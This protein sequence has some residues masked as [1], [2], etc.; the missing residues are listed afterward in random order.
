MSG[1]KPEKQKGKKLRK[2]NTT[3]EHIAYKMQGLTCLPP[4]QVNKTN[5]YRRSCHRFVYPLCIFV[6]CTNAGLYLE[7]ADRGLEV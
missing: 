1:C 2:K 6:S 5:T 4:K 3:H 7:H